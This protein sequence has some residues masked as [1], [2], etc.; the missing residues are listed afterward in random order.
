MIER[1]KVGSIAK[2]NY[3]EVEMSS[4]VNDSIFI[5][6]QLLNK[7]CS[8]ARDG[9]FK[10]VQDMLSLIN[11][12]CRE[13]QEKEKTLKKVSEKIVFENLFK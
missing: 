5:Y 11:M 6:N 4:C 13:T 9:D 7:L 2:Q 3:F 8:L 1:F 12:L 10:G